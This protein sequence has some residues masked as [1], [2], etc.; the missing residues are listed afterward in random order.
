MNRNDNLATI[1]RLSA[2]LLL[3]ASAPSAL[4]QLDNGNGEEQEDP[5]ADLP[6]QMTITGT[7][8]DFRGI[9][10]QNGHP[11]FQIQPQGG[12]G[13]YYGCAADQLDEDGKPAFA[14][15][16][17]RQVSP[18]TD[19]QGRQIIPNKNYISAADGDQTGSMNGYE[20]GALSGEENF[21]QWFRDVPGVNLS[22]MVP[23][24]L[25]RTP[26]TAI[27]TFDDSLDE[28]YQPLGGFFPIN[29]ELFGDYNDSGKNY[30]FTFEM[31]TKFR[32][33]QGSGQVFTFSGDDAIW[34][35]IDGKLV[36]DL[37]GVHGEMSQTIDLDRLTWLEDGG[38]YTLK[39]FFAERHTTQSNFRIDTTIALK[40]VATQPASGLY[41]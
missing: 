27:Y 15:T 2:G 4:A 30:H 26:G 1:L 25:K 21:E 18:W 33:V 28:M 16:G 11:D 34:V 35:Y 7:A 36:I 10:E 13:L 38:F 22:S 9:D 20:G 24:T 5:Y 23:I 14:S 31:E 17:F 8:R 39:L 6:A 41:D 29:G 12:S 32:Y 37:G 19:S 40:N 3:L